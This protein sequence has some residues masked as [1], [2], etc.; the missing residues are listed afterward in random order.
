MHEGVCVLCGRG[1]GGRGGRC[2]RGEG[3]AGKAALEER[4]DVVDGQQQHLLPRVLL[5]K[6]VEVLGEFIQLVP[7]WA[8]L[9]LPR[10]PVAC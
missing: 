7:A 6:G 1:R 4:G 3:A 5:R 8:S 10:L 2:G 9:P